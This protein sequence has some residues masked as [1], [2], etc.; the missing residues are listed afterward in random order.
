[1]QAG[2]PDRVV[3]AVRNVLNGL[4]D[5]EASRNDGCSVPYVTNV[6]FYAENCRVRN[7]LIDLTN[8]VFVRS[9]VNN[10]RFRSP[11]RY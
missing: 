6:Y 9:A 2:N 3:F 7:R 8:L 11:I 5:N 1:M 10:F 4:A